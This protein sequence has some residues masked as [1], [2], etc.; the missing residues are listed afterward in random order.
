MAGQIVMG[1]ARTLMIV[2]MTALSGRSFSIGGGRVYGNLHV[3]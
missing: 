1:V 3:Y 2:G